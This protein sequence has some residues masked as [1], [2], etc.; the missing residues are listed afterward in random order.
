MVRKGAADDEPTLTKGEKAILDFELS[1]TPS[2]GSRAEEVR[3][4]FGISLSA[5][6]QRRAKVLVLPAAEAYAPILVRRLRKKT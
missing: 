4:R 1:W 3:R 6:Y 5:Y 2:R